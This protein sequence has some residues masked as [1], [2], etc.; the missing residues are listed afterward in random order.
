[1]RV[2]RIHVPGPLAVGA[3]V[4]LPPQAGEHLVRV[5][6]LEPGTPLVLFDGRG[7]EYAAT[8]GARAGKQVG[9]R[10]TAQVAAER[11]SPLDITLLQ[12]IARG[13][14]M[15]LIVQKATELGV[16]RIVP[17]L[18][19]RSVVRVE[20][21]QK[22]RKRDHWQG[23]VTSACEQ[24][25][26][27]VVPDVSE[28]RGLGDAVAALPAEAARFLLSADG[29]ETLTAFAQRTRGRPLVLL[30]GPE[31]GIADSES[32]FARANGFVGCRL[33]P[34]I[35]RTE[36]AGLAALATLQAIAGDFA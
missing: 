12:G 18:A 3:D 27:N 16:T 11:E 30:I 9:A 10:I 2:T 36:T 14:R 25:G 29:E 33:G 24:C 23:I 21:K 34:R 5:L 20:A 26:R 13:E 22:D 6:R 4:A 15:D 7:G 19:E 17:V 8:L 31:G 32:R 35:L 1:M 28:P